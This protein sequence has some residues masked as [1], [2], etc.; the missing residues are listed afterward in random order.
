MTSSKLRTFYVQ[1]FFVFVAFIFSLLAQSGFYGFGK[2]FYFSYSKP[3]WFYGDFWD[4]LGFFI[5]T[6]TIYEIKLGIFLTSLSMSLGLN[7]LI[8]SQ[9]KTDTI[10]KFLVVGLIYIIILHTW[11]IIMGTSNAM[12]QGIAMGLMFYTLALLEKGEKKKA[13]LAGA[14][15]AV[16]H[17]SAIIFICLLF[18]VH[19]ITKFGNSWPRLVKIIY[20]LTAGVSVAVAVKFAMPTSNFYSIGVD[21]RLPLTVVGFIYIGMFLIMGSSSVYLAGFL[22]SFVFCASSLLVFGYNWQVERLWM[23]VLIIMIIEVC[24]HF[25]GKQKVLCLL[26]ASILFLALTFGAGNYKSLAYYGKLYKESQQIK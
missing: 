21:L 25:K 11:P 5:A 19:L 16:S 13:V 1:F 24:L 15:L 14:L 20:F 7:K 2:D 6:L 3:N 8:L 26:S 4:R 23:M 9:F 10:N 18:A 22:V 17:K 12:R